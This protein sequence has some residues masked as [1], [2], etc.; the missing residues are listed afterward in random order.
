MMGRN[1]ISEWEFQKTRLNSSEV[2][3]FKQASSF[4]V[5]QAGSSFLL[6]TRT[7]PEG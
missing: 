7:G 6:V 1:G 3:T 5:E 4:K 2:R